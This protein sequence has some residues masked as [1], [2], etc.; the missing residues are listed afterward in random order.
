VHAIEEGRTLFDNLKKTIA[1]TL[2]HLLP[3]ILPIFLNLAFAFP[4]AMNGLMILTIDLLT[5]QG[6]AISLAYERAEEAV[7]SRQPRNLVTDRLV[8]APSLFYSYIIAGA[9]NAL[10]S[11][12]CFFL[13][14]MKRGI[15]ISQLRG[16]L[17]LGYFASPPFTNVNGDWTTGSG[18]SATVVPILVPANCGSPCV[19]LDA[20]AQWNLFAE[21]QSAWY[22]TLIMCQFWHI[23]NCRTRTTS[24]FKHGLFTNVV[25]LYGVVAE[26]AI[27]A[28]VIYIPAFHATSAFQTYSLHGTFWLPHFI[29]VGWIFGYNEITKYLIRSRPNAPWIRFI[30]W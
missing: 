24:I 25:T 14:Y 21:S 4:L 15:P 2:A 28:A 19:P 11:M 29:Y 26:V 10:I 17:N 9:A 5:E 3:E 22:L 6:P 8:T 16:S 20:L 7:M 18:S 30:A 23:W 12:F 27:M 13:V 1:Y